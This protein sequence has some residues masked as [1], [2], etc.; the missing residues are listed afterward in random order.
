MWRC[1]RSSIAVAAHT[2]SPSV[3]SLPP[4]D[5]RD[6]LVGHT[7]ASRLL[8]ADHPQ[9]M[10]S[11]VQMFGLPA[12]WPVIGELEHSLR[13]GFPTADN[14]LP[15]GVWGYLSG[16]PEASRIFDEA[17]TAKAHGQVAGVVG[18]YDFSGFRVIGDIGGGRG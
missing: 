7:V 13:T 15:G 3:Q 11:L 1:R 18:A 8:R 4:P 10:R 6:G 5:T 12:F 16:N 17:I 14:V 2:P 9:S